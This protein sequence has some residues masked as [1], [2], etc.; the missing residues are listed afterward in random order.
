MTTVNISENDFVELW[1]AKAAEDGNLFTYEQI[2]HQDCRKVW[3]I[4]DDG[5]ETENWYAQPGCHVVNVL[6]YVLTDRPWEGNEQALWIEA[7]FDLPAEGSDGY[8]DDFADAINGHH[9]D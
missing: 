2:K 8:P 4:V 6:G 3:S 7:D 9:D 1:G 5:G